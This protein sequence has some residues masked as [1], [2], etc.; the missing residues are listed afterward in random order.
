MLCSYFILKYNKY[1]K[2]SYGHRLIFDEWEIHQSNS[3]RIMPPLR[4]KGDCH[5]QGKWELNPL[6]ICSGT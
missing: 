1:I 3:C 6:S 2:F 4:E 5:Q